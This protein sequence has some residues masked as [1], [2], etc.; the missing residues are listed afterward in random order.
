MLGRAFAEEEDREGY[1]G[2]AVLSHAFWMSRYGGDPEVLGRTVLLDGIRRTV[3]GVMSPEFRFPVP[4]VAAWLS[5]AI[6][7]NLQNRGSHNF[8]IVGRLR[9]GV[10]AASAEAELAAVTTR[11][12]RE[13]ANVHTWHPAYLRSLRDEMVGDVSR[14]RSHRHRHDPGARLLRCRR[15]RRLL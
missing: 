2:V 4:D 12:A 1:D 7:Q 3:V 6:T 15:C 14:A 5:L 9:S 8:S 11:L 13:D 10:T